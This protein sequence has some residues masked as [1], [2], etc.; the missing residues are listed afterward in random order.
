MR[1]AIGISGSPKKGGNTEIL[2]NEALRAIASKGP[3]TELLSIAGKSIAAS[4]GDDKLDLS[5]CDDAHE[6]IQKMLEADAIIV[7]SPVYFRNV[8][9]Q[10]KALMDRTHY[11]H[12]GY[13]LRGKL[14]GAIVVT[15]STGVD[16]TLEV[17]NSFFLQ[18]RMIL[19]HPGAFARLPRS[20][21][22]RD[23]EAA[24]RGASDLG[25]ALASLLNRLDR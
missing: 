17:I 3:R 19:C 25:N 21:D 18:H 2:V 16:S 20:T 4:T 13:R 7:G 6:F 11:L 10:L 1:K 15:G 8:S 5:I 12:V 9:G 14:G 23:E 22:V 24:L